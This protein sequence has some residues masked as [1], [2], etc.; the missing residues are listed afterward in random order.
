MCFLMAVTLFACTES[1]KG[2]DSKIFTEKQVSDFIA[3]NP[4]WTKNVNTEAETTEK[5]QHKMINISNEADFLTNFPLQLKAISDT[6]VSEQPVKLA[7]FKSFKDATRPK[8]ALLNDLELEIRAIMTAEQVTSLTIDKKY[9]IRGMLY[10]QGKRADVKFFHGAETPVYTL[11]KYTFWNIA[12]K[13][14]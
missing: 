13:G 1:P 12:V 8:E 6:L 3:Q 4:N 14:I 5:F 7:I 11:G 10:K 2:V 9:T